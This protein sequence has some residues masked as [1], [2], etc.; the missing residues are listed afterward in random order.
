MPIPFTLREMTPADSPA[1]AA[2]TEQSPDAGMVTVNPRFHLPVDQV[3][4]ARHGKLV[5]VV[6]E[7]EGAPG[8]VGAEHVSFGECQ[9][10]G[11]VR[12]YAL[13]SA[14]VVHP[15]YRRQGIAGALAQW[16][17]TRALEHSGK[18][19]VLMADI[20]K[21]NV[22][23]TATAHQWA[24][25]FSTR[26]IIAPIPM[27]A[28]PPQPNSSITIRETAD[29]DL[30]AI[31][32]NVNTFYRDYNFYRPQTAQSLRDWLQESPLPT[33]INHAWV[34]VDRANHLLAGI[35]VR[36][37]GRLMS[38]HVEK[39]PTLVN[40]A[41]AFL[42]IIPPDHEMRNLQVEKFWFAPGQ[43]EAA[44]LLWQTLRWELRERGSSLLCNYDPRSPLKAVLQAPPWMPTTS[45]NVA[46][47]A[48]A[49]LSESRLLDPIP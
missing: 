10:E 22:A 39:A 2:L 17:I 11:S 5:G 26:V 33:P 1:L 13:M 41:N 34:A 9:F 35:G 24:T 27:R 30:E 38:L 48:P 49:P 15:D 47:R 29:S 43:I 45:I 14:L 20:Q 8:L 23:S 31:A 46:L 19:T 21:G 32:E 44:R 18:D 4:A 37:D 40:L 7:A 16:C 25:Q 6:V 12:P 36:E 42:K 3:F 28:Q